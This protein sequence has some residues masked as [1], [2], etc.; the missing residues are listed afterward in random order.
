MTVFH[1]VRQ[2]FYIA[3]N[4]YNST[5]LVFIQVYMMFE[6]IQSRQDSTRTQIFVDVRPLFVLIGKQIKVT[7]RLMR[8]LAR[9][10]EVSA[11]ESRSTKAMPK[12]MSSE[13]GIFKFLKVYVQ[14][15]Q[16]YLTSIVYWVI[17]C[18][19]CSYY[20][21]MF[22]YFCSNSSSSSCLM[23][24]GTYLTFLIQLLDILLW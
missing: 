16:I 6:I 20:L 21:S 8:S 4:Q 13:W 18:L 5:F 11:I 23:Y 7:K 17:Y 10:I 14:L 1:Y 15:S 2:Q 9:G 3:V 12:F 19:A 24:S 22:S